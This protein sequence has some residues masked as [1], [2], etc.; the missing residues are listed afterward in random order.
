MTNVERKIEA[1][2]QE[3]NQEVSNAAT[4]W[5]GGDVLGAI[6]DPTGL[7]NAGGNMYAGYQ[8][9]SELGHPAAGLILG[10]EGAAGARSKHDDSVSVGDVYTKENVLK[11]ALQG[12]V[13][14]A[15]AGM[16]AGAGGGPE[17][18]G[19][20]ALGGALGGAV[21]GAGGVP[22][23][24]YGLGKLFGGQPSENRTIR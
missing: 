16:V 13:T 6:P 24:R 4:K 21:M 3:A 19:A 5:R 20:G 1:L 2:I 9:G 7:I 12:G 23:I 8:A 15:T 10:Q 14:G 11:R 18:M 22:G 17:V